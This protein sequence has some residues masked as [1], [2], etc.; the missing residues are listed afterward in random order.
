MNPEVLVLRGRGAMAVCVPYSFLG[1]I[2]DGSVGV[3]TFASFPCLSLRAYLE[4]LE[5]QGSPEAWDPKAP[6]DLL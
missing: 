4:P 1:G 3:L 6:W 5:S 2:L